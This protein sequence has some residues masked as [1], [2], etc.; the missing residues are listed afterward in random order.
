[1]TASPPATETQAEPRP[2][3]VAVIT[4]WE[5]VSFSVAHGVVS[6]L[7]AGLGLRGLHRFGRCFGT[8]EWMINF[9][10]RRRFAR[11]L[12]HI[13]GEELPAVRRRR[14]TRAWFM[15]SRCDR[16]FYLVFDRI[17]RRQAMALFTVE[18]RELLDDALTLGRGA[19]VAMSHHGP[20][21]VA[22]LLLSLL[23]YKTA[24]VRERHESG[25]KRFIQK[26]LDERYPEFQRMR[27]IF[28]DSFAREIY[29]CYQEGYVVGS[30]L[31]VRRVRRPNQKAE[32][33]RLFGR[34]QQLLTGPLRIALRCGTP[35]LQAFMLPEP[36]FRYRFIIR[37]LVPDPGK[38]E[39][40]DAT[41]AEA[42]RAYASEMER[43][44]RATPHLLSRV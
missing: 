31:D 12:A 43:C 4:P 7:L 3:D 9:K 34:E 44:V 5:H 33:V 8:I 23:G 20:H 38:V 37:P 26:R 15:Q 42:A 13:A 18:G 36:G 14:V 28:E 16:L 30:L 6:L 1:M 32:T 39:D 22:A 27:V 19:N 24:G 40:E 21:H 2:P 17:D 11:A 29:R 35:I 41:V 25:M 10:R